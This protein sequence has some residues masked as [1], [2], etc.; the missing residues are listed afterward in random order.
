M[1]QAWATQASATGSDSGSS[2]SRSAAAPR[3][4]TTCATVVS[5][6]DRA[7]P[8]EPRGVDAPAPVDE[9]ELGERLDGHGR[10]PAGQPPAI[11]RRR[12]TSS[13]STGSSRTCSACPAPVVTIPK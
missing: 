4:G 11:G 6:P 3:N 9:R 13:A 12:I 7:E 1:I 10:W 2:A 8:L 5:G